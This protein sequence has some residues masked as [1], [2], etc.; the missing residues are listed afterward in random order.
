[1]A[2][3]LDASVNQ[4]FSSRLGFLLSVIGIAVGT[5]NIWRFPR[6]AAQNGSEE[7][8][9]AFLVAG[10]VFLFLWS[11]PLVL[12]EYAMGRKCRMGVVGTIAR[13]AG[14][15]F[16]WMGA[17]M[18]FVTAAITFFYSVVLGWCLYY[19]F[20][21]LINPL[22]L[23]TEVA[24]T[25]WNAYQGSGWP[26]V[27]HA[28]VMGFGAFAIWRGVRSI[29]RVNKILI[30]TLLAI[31]LISVVR[32]LTLPGAWAGVA[33]LFTPDWGQ[34][35][36]PTIWMEALTQNA[37]DVGA[38]WG[39]YL[40]YAAYVRREYGMVK[41]GFIT[42]ISNNLV[43]MLAALMLF[44]TVFAILRAE[45]SMTQPEVLEIM[46]NS[47]EAST[48]LTFIWMPQLFARMFMGRPLSILFFLGL[49]FAGFSS[50]IAH[51]ELSTRVLIDTGLKRSKA[52]FLVT[53]VI[54]LL[55]I[56]SAI[57]LNFLKNQDFVWGYALII[58]GALAA[59]AVKR[60]G[61]RRLRQEE[62]LA[63]EKDWKLG[64]WWDVVLVG[65]VPLGAIILLVWWLVKAAEP[66]KWYNPLDP[67]SVMNCLVQWFVVLGILLLIGRW[68]GRRVL[69]KNQ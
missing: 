1:M 22:P 13:I 56:P 14:E 32:G 63:D 40:T 20:Q 19:F 18:T 60:Y 41:N 65:F 23:T 64:R 43:S 11:I 48:G 45:M 53:M 17:F 52:I 36:R 61:A 8:A 25:R 12:A 27:T 7:G 9:G 66:G 55:G 57:S 29:E 26:L 37:W 38:G 28:V 31:V 49:T 30:P 50:L 58:S 2:A 69:A 15:K 59:F 39:L 10:T 35:S 44:S 46:R 6:I 33:Y 3:N 16:A 68:L 67:T 62:L 54:Y 4:R 5:G 24:M 21:M 51:L 34:L 42:P 47:G